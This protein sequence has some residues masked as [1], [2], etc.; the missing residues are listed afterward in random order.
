MCSGCGGGWGWSARSQ[1]SSPAPSGTTSATATPRPASS[2][3][4]MQVELPM[5]T[6]S[7]RSCQKATAPRWTCCNMHSAMSQQGMPDACAPNYLASREL[8]QSRQQVWRIVV[9][10]SLLPFLHLIR[11]LQP[12]ASPPHAA[13]PCLA[14]NL[15]V[16]VLCAGRGGCNLAVRGSEA[17]GGHSQGHTEGPQDSAAGRGHQ[18]S[19]C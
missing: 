8:G 18:C 7:L 19:G 11:R 12:S 1:S 2:K 16:W 5:H 10:R 17:K 15:L 3:S 6:P 9:N 14:L 4:R 13:V